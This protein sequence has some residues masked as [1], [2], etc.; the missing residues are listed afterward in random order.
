MRRPSAIET[1]VETA[2][3]DANRRDARN[4]CVGIAV[5]DDGGKFYWT[6][7]GSDNAGEGRIFRANLELPKWEPPAKRT[8]IELLFDGL[9]EPI[10]LDLDL[11]N[12]TMYWTDRGEPQDPSR[13]CLRTDA[14]SPPRS[15][16]DLSLLHRTRVPDTV[17]PN[18]HQ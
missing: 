11:P 16:R 17:L 10:Y 18:S 7:K 14:D 15:V 5:D 3:G 2:H 13:P 1:L 8:D 9:P 6:Q 4:W 12:R